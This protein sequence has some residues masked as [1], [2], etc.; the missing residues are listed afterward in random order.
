MN[1][2][3]LPLWE[4]FFTE[5][6]TGPKQSKQTVPRGRG[7]ASD[8]PAPEAAGALDQL[9]PRLQGRALLVPNSAGQTEWGETGM[10][11]E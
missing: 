10:S 4:G 8:E 9:Q 6:S 7:T 2:A 5:M 11:Q 3:L 1:H